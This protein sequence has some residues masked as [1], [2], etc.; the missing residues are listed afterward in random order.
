VSNQD[1]ADEA[2]RR[3][4]EICGNNAGVP[5][6]V[7]AVNDDF[8]VPIPLTMKVVGFFQPASAA[9]IAPDLRDDVARRLANGSGWT[10]VAT[11]A[12]GRVGAMLGA[13][14]EQDAI[15]GAMADCAKHDSACRVI[16][17]G[18]FAVEPN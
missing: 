4:L 8:V 15:A 3:V 10:A 1:S 5:C 17:I 18:P 9:A 6:L 14:S 7:L 16:G 13:A 2:V 11:G 12:G